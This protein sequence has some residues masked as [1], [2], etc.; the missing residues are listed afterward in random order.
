MRAETQFIHSN[1]PLC[2]TAHDWP[3]RNTDQSFFHVKSGRKSYHARTQVRKCPR[4]VCCDQKLL[5]EKS[6]KVSVVVPRLLM[7]IGNQ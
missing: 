2:P 6:L 5:S 4:E 1:E 7:G 3:E